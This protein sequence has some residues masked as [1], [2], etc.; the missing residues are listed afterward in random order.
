[1]KE[2]NVDPF[3]K[4]LREYDRDIA[5]FR[6]FKNSCGRLI[7]E[8]LRL[9]NIR[10]H[11]VTARVK[12]RGNLLEKIKR[13]GKTYDCAADVTDIVGIRVITHFEDE[14]DKIGSLI[15]REF[16]INPEKSVDKRKLLDPDRFGYLSLHYI[17]SLLPDRLK[18]AENRRFK[19]L[20][21]EIQIR[22]IL[23]HSWAEIEHDLGYKSGHGVPAPIRR[24]FSRLAGLLEV[25]DQE[26]AAIRNDLAEYE[27]RVK[28]E[29]R[30]A[31]SEVGIDK[32][33]LKAFF[34]ENSLCRQIEDQL[35]S[36]LNNRTLVETGDG[37][38]ELIANT[39]PLLGI[40][41]IKELEEGLRRHK[42]LLLYEAVNRLR[43]STSN[44]NRG[45]SLIHLMIILMALEGGEERIKRGFV[46][47]GMP[48]DD[49]L[50]KFVQDVM[51]NVRE[52]QLKHGG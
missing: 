42:D 38:F 11:S 7:T 2:T 21:C 34:K 31:P 25:A 45:V 51:T 15:E 41:T 16:V 27:S 17:C 9:E 32:I 24:R 14:V 19:D 28:T 49:K 10:V 1:M 50:T 13:E 43:D 3:A 36:S 22:S 33:S 44:L 12:E 5:T 48:D 20:I 52:Y 40:N 30:I 47:F 23:Q 6:D 37:P 35:S 29:I 39:L 4:I 26:F 18:L 8:L 46:T